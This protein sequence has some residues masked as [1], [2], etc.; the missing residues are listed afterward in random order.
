MIF[1]LVSIPMLSG[2]GAAQ[3]AGYLVNLEIWGTL[4]DS[5]AL[6][7]IVEQYKKINPYVGQ[8][9]YRKFAQA[10]YKQ[11]LLDALAAGQGPD[12]FLIGNGWLPSFENK[13]EPAPQPFMSEQD[14][15]TN[16]PDVVTQDFFDGGKAWAAPLSIDSMALYYN[17][18]IFNAA[19]IANPPKDWIEFQSDVQ[20]I[21]KIN[22]SGNFDLSGAAIGT[23]LNINRSPDLLS[24]LMLQNGVL[25][26]KTKADQTRLDEGVVNKDGKTYQ[27]G[28]DALGFYTQFAKAGL[29]SGVTNQSYTWN[30]RQ[31]YSVDAFSQGSVAMMFNYSWQIAE[32]RN[33]NPKLNFAIAPMPQVNSAAPATYANYW[34][35]AVSR[36]K[37]APVAAVANGQPAVA[38]IS[39]ETRTHEAW[40]FI[41]FLTLKNTGTIKLY[42]AISKNSKD[43]PINFDPADEYLK[44]TMQPPARRDLIEAKKSDINLGVFANGNL[45]AKHW[46]QSDPD[47]ID[48]IFVDMI[49]AV[50]RGDVSLHEALGLAKNKIN[51]LSGGAR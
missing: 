12:I 39:N 27:P 13:L 6:A 49:E 28:E 46:Y 26:P 50:V 20:K 44:K 14:I 24:T 7:N 35:Y 3:N 40:Q 48:K 43:F 22:A 29:S 2:C 25:L 34:G 16:F 51:Y 45:I 36:N 5:A 37:I 19:G 47:A 33:K 18:D 21:T 32:I 23:G 15:K 9:K 41:C 10:T 30:N 1:M 4:D 8:I 11:E 17:K 31:H 42:N 38:P